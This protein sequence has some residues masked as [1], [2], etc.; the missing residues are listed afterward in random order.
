MWISNSLQ[1]VPL[2]SSTGSMNKED[3][4]PPPPGRVVPLTIEVDAKANIELLEIS[5][6]GSY[7]RGWYEDA[8][9]QAAL[10]EDGSKRREIIFACCFAESYLVEWVRDSVLKE[11]SALAKFFPKGVRRGI[12]QRWKE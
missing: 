4:D 2:Q 5:A 12:R 8:R 11:V 1:S 6:L 10:Q 9:T 7:A 3:S